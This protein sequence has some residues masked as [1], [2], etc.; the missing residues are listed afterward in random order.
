MRFPP[1][2][3][4]KGIASWNFMMMEALVDII[5]YVKI[6]G[7]KERASE[8]LNRVTLGSYQAFL[9]A[10]SNKK[11][12]DNGEATKTSIQH[13]TTRPDHLPYSEDYIFFS[14][15]QLRLYEISGQQTFLDNVVLT[16]P[17]LIEKF[18]R[19]THK[20]VMMFAAEIQ[21]MTT[22]QKMLT[23][24]EISFFD[25]S[26]RSPAATLIH[27][28]KRIQTILQAD[29]MTANARYS[30]SIVQIKACEPL[31]NQFIDECKNTILKAPKY[32]GEALKALTYPSEAYRRI[33]VPV[34][35]IQ[36]PE[37]SQAL[38][39]FMPRF[40]FTYH[41]GQEEGKIEKQNWWQVCRQDACEASGNSFETF[42]QALGVK[43]QENQESSE[44][45]NNEE[46]S[47]Q[48]K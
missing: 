3:D 39:S 26:F 17:F 27:L 47:P 34:E 1:S 5:Q 6:D 33:E 18:V 41:H 21:D 23:S 42:V 9:K 19:L 38:S 25:Q 40:V 43:Q 8:L 48:E 10:D 12:D 45:Q 24:L 7:I 15:L 16:L 14:S 22:E 4:T 11:Q 37:F 28:W 13:S 29:M 46:T 35:W 32:A 30:D 2:T 20:P 36:R 31:M 44:N